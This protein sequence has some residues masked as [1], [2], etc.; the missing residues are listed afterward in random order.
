MLAQKTRRTLSGIRCEEDGQAATPKGSY[1][2]LQ[3]RADSAGIVLTVTCF[4]LAPATTGA[5]VIAAW[6]ARTSAKIGFRRCGFR[7]PVIS[8]GGY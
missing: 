6:P 8:D 1:R 2:D 3:P 5:R 7:A 4:E